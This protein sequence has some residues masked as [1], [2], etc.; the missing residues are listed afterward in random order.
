M[1]QEHQILIRHVDPELKKKF[2]VH[3]AYR[4]KNMSQVITEF[5]KD[6]TK[7][8]VLPNGGVK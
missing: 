8:I 1:E 6:V 5:I 7:N 4:C 3:C 2:K